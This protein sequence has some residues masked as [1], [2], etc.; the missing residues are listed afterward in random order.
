MRLS[1]RG[2][3]LNPSKKMIKTI[4]SLPI[5]T[6]FLAFRDIARI[7]EQ[8]VS[9]VKALDFGCGAGRSTRIL[10][11]NGLTVTGVDTSEDMIKKAGDISK[12]IEFK[13]VE[14]NCFDDVGSQYDLIFLSF[15]LM[16]ISSTEE[17]TVLI[18][19]LSGLLS[20]EGK[21]ILI[22]ASDDFYTSDWLSVDTKP[23]SNEL[24]QSGNIVAVYLKDYHTEIHDYLW[25]EEDVEQCFIQSD[26]IVVKKLKPLG[27]SSDKK[28]WVDEYTKAPFVLYVIAKD[29]KL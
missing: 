12:D 17:I 27:V 24:K 16:E 20:K 1:P 29:N 13:W 7:L 21:I 2:K 18:S 19:K 15:V 11:E 3:A 4:G 23:Y 25:R 22:V 9:G 14:K 5:G 28:K 26:M 8:Y 10:K 6:G